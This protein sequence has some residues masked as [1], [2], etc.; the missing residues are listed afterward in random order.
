[1]YRI[2]IGYDIHRLIE[3]RQLII[4]GI[5]I[6]YE[7]GLDGHSDADV[8]IHAIIDSLLGALALGDIGQHFPDTDK[9]YKNADSKVLL[10]EVYG[11]VKDK[12][13]V[14]NNLDSNIIAERPK[15]REHI[16]E[17]RKTLSEILDIERPPYPRVL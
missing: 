5:E 9:K 16:A 2:G 1:M 8:L 11:L 10:K 12:G 3:N 14:I 17:M 6:P 13:Y 4:G 7:K 15:M